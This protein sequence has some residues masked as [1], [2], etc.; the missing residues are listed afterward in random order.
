[1]GWL[2]EV[3]DEDAL[4]AGI[5]ELERIRQ[6]QAGGSAHSRS[7]FA[8]LVLS[9]AA[10]RGKILLDFCRTLQQEIANFVN[11]NGESDPPQS[12]LTISGEF[13][14]GMPSPCTPIRPVSIAYSP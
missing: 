14:Y 5:D 9:M 13:L 1:M 6:G 7:C 2:L 8:H 4:L 11:G 10:E 12:F 3:S